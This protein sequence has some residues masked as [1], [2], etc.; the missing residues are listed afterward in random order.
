MPIIPTTQIAPPTIVP[1]Q[2]LNRI[3]PS[4]RTGPTVAAASA[5]S[6]SYRSVRYKPLKIGQHYGKKW[7]FEVKVSGCVYEGEQLCSSI[8]KRPYT[9]IIARSEEYSLT[10][11]RVP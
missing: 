8:L 1:M 3:D 11:D 5:A 2:T 7:I 10:F 9:F 6:S 4:T